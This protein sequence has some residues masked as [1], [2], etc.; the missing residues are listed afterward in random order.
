MSRK[1][2]KDT[3]D[4]SLDILHNVAAKPLD[5]AFHPQT[6]ALIGATD[7]KGSVGATLMKN[8]VQKRQHRKIFPI[9]PKKR[10]IMGIKA[11]K[12]IV[13]VKDKIDLAIIATPAKTVPG[14]IKECVMKKVTVAIIISAGFKEMGPEGQKL[15]KEIRKLIKNS[16]LRI[17]GPNCLGIMRPFETL[18]ASFAA[19]SPAK[20]K[21]AFISQSGALC[22][23]VLDWS[24]KEKVGFSAFVSIGSMMDVDWGDLID[25]FGHDPHT[26][27][28]LIYMEDIGDARS[29]LTSAREVALIKPIIIIKAGVTEESAKAAT[30]HTGALASSNDVLNAAFDRSGVLR[31]DSIGDLFAMAD[32]LSK[33]PLPK[34]PHLSIITN[35]GGPGVIATDAL[36]QSHAKLA[37][38]TQKTIDAL[39]KILPKAWSHNNPIDILGDALPDLFAKTLKIALADTYSDGVLIILTPQYMTDPTKTAKEI[40][41][42]VKKPTKPILASW[43]GAKT[44]GFGVQ[45][46]QDKQIATFEYPDDAARVF[47]YM[48]TY[49]SNLHGIYETPYYYEHE[50]QNLRQ[51]KREKIRE[52]F[53]NARKENRRILTEE[54]SKRVIELIDI[55]I[56][57]TVV[58]TSKKQAVE[59]AQEIGFPVVL[60]LLSKTIT[61]KSEVGGV[62][63][64]LSNANAVEKAYD[65]IYE[66]LKQLGKEKEF[67][68]VCVQRMIKPEGFELILG[69][70]IDPNFGPVILFGQG[71]VLVE[72]HQDKVLALPPLTTT[73][74]GRMMKKTKIYKALK[75]FRKQKGVNLFELEKILVRFSYFI[76]EFD[77]I[78]ECDI[79]PFFA[80]NTQMIAM[81][82]RIVLTDPAKIRPTTPIRPYPIDYIKSVV[83]KD[84]S[85]AIIRPIKPEDESLLYKFI[86]GL[87]HKA[88]L[89]RFL[90]D[91]EYDA[92]L[93]KQF[94]IHFCCSDYSKEIN[95]VVELDNARPQKEIVA[96]GRVTKELRGKTASFAL[97]VQD[98]HQKKGIGLLLLDQLIQVAKSEGVKTLIAHMRKENE[99]MQK[100]CL[101]KGF[102]LSFDR[103]NKDLIVATKKL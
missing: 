5:K 8:L 60:K 92:L 86:V 47:G 57:K 96:M 10:K 32:I 65:A 71:G 75:G 29:F 19:E 36:I 28:I 21:I 33:Q 78:E 93:E 16:D 54:E 53:A 97:I 23:A 101:N 99:T 94:L 30:S 40:I 95:L 55:P 77:E 38:L 51:Q 68:G 70:S 79:N 66:R 4:P 24:L 26:E 81:D 45:L 41:K 37:P 73:L 90:K 103:Q 14:I 56:V 100:I 72:I 9:N 87:S 74:A 48:W 27:S 88:I 59:Q 85:K 22:T 20:G 43:M 2:R 44:V 82:A 49:Q 11:Y 7:R 63:L 84:E 98:K 50:D 58:A 80:S 3:F 67:D 62:Q 52:I 17:I 102:S 42:Q 25:Y 83:L 1:T 18:N 34:G 31:V 76:A 6:I 35:A 91:F 64:N 89:D 15:E 39:N 61:H 12:S 46:L 69:S 13:D